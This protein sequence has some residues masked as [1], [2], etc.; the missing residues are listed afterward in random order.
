MKDK[1]P[2]TCPH[3]GHPQ[4]EPAQAY[5]TVCRGCRRHFLVQEAL[6][7]VAPPLEPPRELKRFACF[8]CGGLLEAPVAAQ[9]TMCKHCGSHVDLHDYRVANAVPRNFKT[10]GRLVIE[11]TGFLFNTESVAGEV[12]LKGRLLGRLT[13][14]RSLEIH[15]SAEIKGSFKTDRLIISA[16][17]I[18]RWPEV[19]AVGGADIAGELV[20]NLNAEGKV[21][22]KSTARY[23]GQLRAGDLVVESGAVWVGTAKVGS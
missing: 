2:V 17:S 5:S 22:L 4:L 20:A 10:K 19:I 1:V 23:F 14:E 3:C 13:A 9:S 18:F 21:V 6:H 11:E 15:H 8:T 12:I 16:G 7:P